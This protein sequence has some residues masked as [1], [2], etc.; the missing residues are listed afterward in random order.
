MSKPKPDFSMGQ[1]VEELRG[2]LP[3]IDAGGMRTVEI[4]EPIG[5]GETTVRKLLRG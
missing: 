4:A 3:E 1:I 5:F 2:A